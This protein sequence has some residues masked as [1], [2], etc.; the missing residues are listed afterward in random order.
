MAVKNLFVVSLTGYWRMLY[1]LEFNQIE[2]VAFI[3]NI[4]DHP[5]YDKMS[6]YKK[7]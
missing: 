1:A 7:K 4:V 2:I 5:T 6:G 3:L